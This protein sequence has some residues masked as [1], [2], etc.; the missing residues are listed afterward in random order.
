MLFLKVVENKILWYNS[1]IP[2]MINLQESQHES[3]FS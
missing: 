1:A 3:W 2:Q